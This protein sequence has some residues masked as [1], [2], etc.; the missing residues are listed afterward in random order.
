[1]EG[2]AWR[3]RSVLRGEA[4]VIEQGR[5]IGFQGWVTRYAHL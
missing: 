4:E 1:M 5:F 2:K 3:V